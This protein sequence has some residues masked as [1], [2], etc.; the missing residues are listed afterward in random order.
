MPDQTVSVKQDGTGDYTTIQAAIDAADVST[1]YYKIEINDAL[2]YSESLSISGVTGTPTASNYVW[3]TAGTAQ[4]HNGLSSAVVGIKS[5]VSF[6][7]GVPAI[8]IQTDYTRI[9]NLCVSQDVHT[10]TPQAIINVGADNCLLSRLLLEHDQ[11]TLRLL[12]EDFHGVV[13]EDVNATLCIDNCSFRD[14]SGTCVLLKN[15]SGSGYTQNVNVDYCT[16]Q[17]V[18]VAGS[19]TAPGAFYVSSANSAANQKLTINNCFV[20]D[21]GSAAGVVVDA[22]NNLGVQAVVSLSK[23]ALEDTVTVP[24]SGFDIDRF[25]YDQ[26]DVVTTTSSQ[27]WDKITVYGAYD[28]RIEVSVYDSVRCPA[29][30]LGVYLGGSEPDS[31][32]DFSLD[33]RDTARATNNRDVQNKRGYDSN[34]LPSTE[35]GAFTVTQPTD[36]SVVYTD[37]EVVVKQDGTGDFTT[38]QAALDDVDEILNPVFGRYIVTISDSNT[39]DE[40]LSVNANDMNPYSRH[41]FDTHVCIEVAPGHHHAGKPGTGHARI[42]PTSGSGSVIIP[43]FWTSF[44]DLEIEMIGLLNGVYDLNDGGVLISR[45]IFT[46]D[47][48][49]TSVTNNLPVLTGRF[50]SAPNFT[51]VE[52]CLFLNMYH[53][54]RWFFSSLTSYRYR[55]W[56]LHCGIE[57]RDSSVNF[58]A[59]VSP[60]LGTGYAYLYNTWNE[61]NLTNAAPTYWYDGDGLVTVNV[62]S[63]DPPDGEFTITNG[64]TSVL[65]AD[66]SIIVTDSAYTTFD[67]VPPKVANNQIYGTGVDLTLYAPGGEGSGT[68]GQDFRLNLDVDI[69]KNPRI[70]GRVADIG[71]F[72]VSGTD[73]VAGFDNL[74]ELGDGV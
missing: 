56:L 71:P 32:Q 50:S 43:T 63:G 17:N 21:V 44:Y 13:V 73:F 5:P 16:L 6:S 54:T 34:V 1:G 74:L 18:S 47:E 70:V 19:T 36:D 38:I 35:P 39:Y 48:L 31:R 51:L 25:L 57:A 24:V 7:S 37:V 64:V 61:L 9:D 20:Y 52:N 8:D 30:R 69:L 3:L 29:L 40:Q 45:C 14:I 59:E 26:F 11:L 72:Q 66:S 28:P 53:L 15:G 62:D 12:Y 27:Y 60:D 67:G 68:G 55:L 4:R 22:T 41:S 23:N 58:L 46:T 42:A 2:S 10:G 49:N 33:I 65:T